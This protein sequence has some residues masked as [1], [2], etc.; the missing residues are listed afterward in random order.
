ML[1]GSSVT[2]RF[3]LEAEQFNPWLDAAA[4]YLTHT[5]NAFDNNMIYLAGLKAPL[6]S[7]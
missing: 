1:L 6:I 5:L 2:L 3:L 4:G 7:D